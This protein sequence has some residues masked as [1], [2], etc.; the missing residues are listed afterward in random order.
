MRP[1]YLDNMYNCIHLEQN[2]DSRKK[3]AN[4]TQTGKIERKLTLFI[5]ELS[6][7]NRITNGIQMAIVVVVF[8][9]FK[10]SSYGIYAIR[11]QCCMNALTTTV[12]LHI[13][14]CSSNSLKF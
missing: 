1:S 5:A 7:R 11:P 14:Y 12:F 10:A 8:V 6:K 13:F 4:D 2:G 3:S 9:V